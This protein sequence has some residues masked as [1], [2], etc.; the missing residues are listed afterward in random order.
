MTSILALRGVDTD[1]TQ[2]QVVDLAMQSRLRPLTGPA[3]TPPG[4]I[5]TILGT[6]VASPPFAEMLARLAAPAERSERG[7]GA[8]SKALVDDRS[9]IGLKFEAA[10]LTSFLEQLLPSADSEAWGGEHGD[11]WRGIFAQY[12]ADDIASSG[13]IGIA[14]V[15]DD[16]LSDRKSTNIYGVRS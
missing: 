10:T 16:S 13:G 2:V 7:D 9:Q 1:G 14:K 6:P 3:A 12:L 11:M 4:P 15:I 8:A 5:G